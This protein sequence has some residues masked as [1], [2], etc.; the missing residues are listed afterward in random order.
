MRILRLW[1]TEFV[2][3]TCSQVRW[4]LVVWLFGLVH[5]YSLFAQDPNNNYCVNPQGAEVGGFTLDRTRICVGSAVTVVKGSVPANLAAVGYVSQ[6]SGKG[7]PTTFETGPSFTYTK[8]G[9]YTILQVGTSNGLRALA[10]QTIT[11]LPLDPISVTVK[12]CAGRK[13][14][15]TP[16]ISTLGQYDTYIIQWGDGNIEQLSRIAMEANPEHTYIDNGSDTRTITV[17]G[18]YGSSEPFICRSP[19]PPQTVRLV[20]AATQ[21][22]ITSLKTLNDNSISIQY[23]AGTGATVQLL[24][25]IN[26]VYT[27]TGKQDAGTGTFNVQTDARQVQCFQVVAQDVCSNSGIKSDEVCSL[28]L[29]VKPANKKNTLSWQPY[30]GVANGGQFRFYRITRNRTPIGGT[31]VDQNRSSYTDEDNIECGTQYCYSLVAT[32]AGSV[33]QTE[34]TSASVCVTGVNGDVPDSVNNVVVSIENNRPRV[35]VTLAKPVSGILS[36][37]TLVVSRSDGSSGTFRPVGT[38]VNDS[39]FV[40]NGADPSSGSYCYQITYQGVCGLTLPPSK[41]VCTVY[42]SSKANTSLDWTSESPFLPGPVTEYTIEITDSLSGTSQRISLGTSTHYEPKPNDPNASS[43][44]YRIIATSG[45]K[46][47]YSNSLTLFGEAKIWMP[48]A[49]TPNGDQRNDEFLPKGIISE[50]FLMNIYSRWGDIIYSTTDKTKGW[51][52]LINGQPAGTG[53]Y[54]YRVEVED[55]SGHKTVRTGALLLVR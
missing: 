9:S 16:N 28:V 50:R 12:S 46:I 29:D 21:P 3:Q 4:L 45:S 8:P 36:S 7:I 43:Y 22:A 23:Q 25:K 48:D 52:G 2:K 44:T 18:A 32:I 54:M 1:P 51:N 31:V 55:A 24:Q 53:Q 15:V 49:F 30:A 38:I 17:E 6:Y 10:C 47:S 26:G 14:T 33:A 39:V 27:D 19:V 42:L 35:A 41:P 11:V 5:S 40:D 20:P 37:Y 34:V 13:V